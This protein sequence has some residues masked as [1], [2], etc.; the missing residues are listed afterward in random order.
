MITKD[1][2]PW[3]AGDLVIRKESLDAMHSH[4]LTEFPNECCGYASGPAAEPSIVDSVSPMLNLATTD[5]YA[6]Q[7]AGGR[8]S[9][10]FFIMDPLKLDTAITAG[11][12]TDQPVKVVYHSHPNSKGA[13]FSDEDRA[14]FGEGHGLLLPV[15]F[16][17]IGVSN[18]QSGQ[19]SKP[20]VIETKL[21]VFNALTKQF[22]ESNLTTSV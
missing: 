6:N 17:V 9:Q 18:E 15:S 1:D 16:I 19:N 20:Y 21:W 10:N 14:I 3:T 11:D 7:L 5:Q 13:Y 12:A 2:F 4:A 8:T 22:V